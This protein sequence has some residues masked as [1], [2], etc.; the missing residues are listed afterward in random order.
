MTF[1]EKLTL[2]GEGVLSAKSINYLDTLGFTL[3]EV[4]NLLSLGIT[5]GQIELCAD[6]RPPRTRVQLEDFANTIKAAKKKA[7]NKEV[8]KTIGKVFWGLPGIFRNT[9]LDPFKN[10][11][12]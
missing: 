5:N 6:A 9:S 1:N 7:K 12:K 3:K 11:S 4:R 8:A 2:T 10:S